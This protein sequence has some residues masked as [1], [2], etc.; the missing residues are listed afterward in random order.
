MKHSNA[1]HFF[2]SNDVGGMQSVKQRRYS[3][4]I[5]NPETSL[6]TDAVGLSVTKPKEQ[7][8][9]IS[10]QCAGEDIG[11]FRSDFQNHKPNLSPTHT[12][13]RSAF[14][15]VQSQANIKSKKSRKRVYSSTE[16]SKMVTEG[17]QKSHKLKETDS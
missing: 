12:C 13:S 14:S 10:V 15:P 1:S 4:Q 2:E 8:D 3:T 7:N 11:D 9:F 16:F 17:S 6:I 5:K